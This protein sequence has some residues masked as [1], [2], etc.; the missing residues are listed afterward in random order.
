MQAPNED[1]LVAA[2]LVLR[3]LK[4]SPGQGIPLSSQSPPFLTACC[5]SDKEAVLIQ[6]N[7]LLVIASCWEI[8]QCHI[9][10][11]NNLS[12]HSHQQRQSTGQL[13][14]PAVR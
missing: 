1:H 11:R 9:K 13:Q 8:L 3:Y 10:Q 4:A 7:L 14:V 6:G 12:L 5:D 2:K